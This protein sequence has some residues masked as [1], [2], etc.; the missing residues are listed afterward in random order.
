[1]FIKLINIFSFFLFYNIKVMDINLTVLSVFALITILLLCITFQL[2]TNQENF[3]SSSDKIKIINNDAELDKITRLIDNIK[4]NGNYL[5]VLVRHPENNYYPL[6]Q[7]VQVSHEPLEEISPEILQKDP[8]KLMVKN[9]VNPKDYKLVWSSKELDYYDGQDFSVWR[10]ISHKDYQTMGDVFKL[11]FDKPVD[12]ILITTVPNRTVENS[13]ILK[14]E[15]MNLESSNNKLYCWYA[16][17]YHF[18]RCYQKKPEDTKNV[19]DVKNI[20]DKIIK[21]S[22]EI[23]RNKV[24]KFK[25]SG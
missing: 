5:S 3:T 23:K 20:K 4:I 9:G 1:M 15:L 11:G 12:E 22:G 25:L 6:G 10:P 2:T 14:K 7:Y 21:N 18:P 8:L 13:G 16:T 19:S 17:N 24:V